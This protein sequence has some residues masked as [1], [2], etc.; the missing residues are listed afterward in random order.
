VAEAYG[1]LPL[2]FEPNRGQSDPLIRFLARGPGYAVF[3]TPEQALLKLLGPKP[4]SVRMQLAGASADA[5]VEGL[6]ALPGKSH[7]FLGDD[8]ARWRRDIPNYAQ[9][10]VAGVYPG[11]DL[12][13]YGNPQRLEYDFVLAPGSDPGRIRLQFHSLDRTGDIAPRIQDGDLL[14]ETAAG[15]LRFKQPLAYQEIAGVRREIAAHYE[16]HRADDG[17]AQVGFA[18]AAYD[19][20]RPLVID[21]TLVYST[22][23]G[24]SLADIGYGIAVDGSGRAY[25]TGTTSSNPFPTSGGAYDGSFGGGQDVFVARL[26]AAGSAL[27][28]STYLG[29]AGTDIAYGIDIDAGGNAYVTGETSGGF[30]TTDGSGGTIAAY[31]A[32]YGGGASDG[33][34]AKLNNTGSALLYS[35][36]LGGSGAD[37]ARAIAVD[38]AGIAYLTG[39]TTSPSTGGSA[40]PTTAGAFDATCGTEGT[41]NGGA[42]DAFVTRINTATGGA[43][44]LL[45]STYLGGNGADVG[46]AIDVDA[47]A[48]AY[49]TGETLSTN[50]T[51]TTGALDP[52]CGTDGGCNGGK[53]DAFVTKI[54]TAAA[55]GASIAFSTYLGGEDADIGYGIAVD[56]SGNVYITG[57]TGSAGFPVSSPFQG[58]LA[59]APD[60][61]VTKLGSAGTPILYSTFLGG[62]GADSGRAIKVDGGGSAYVTGVT[63]SSNFPVANAFQLDQTADDAFVV[64]LTSGG[65]GLA[66][67]TYFGGAGADRGL[68]VAV[69]ANCNAYITGDTTSSGPPF[70]LLPTGA[71]YDD[72]YNGAG[73][74]FVA[75]I[76]PNANE[77]GCTGGPP[78]ANPTLT[79]AGSGSGSGTVT[80]TGINCTIAAGVTSGDCTESYSTGATA[81]LT[82]SAASGS[83]FGGWSGGSGNCT[84]T[85]TPCTTA[86]LTADATVTATFTS[87]DTA[88]DSFS[89]ISYNAVG[90]GTSYVS[91]PATITGINAAANVSVSGG[92]YCLSSQLGCRCDV[93]DWTTAAGTVT[94]NQSACVRHTSS[95][96]GGVSVTTTLT[97]GGVSSDFT[98]STVTVAPADTPSVQLLINGVAA[99]SVPHAQPLAVGW[100]VSNVVNKELFLLYRTPGAGGAWYFVNAAGQVLAAVDLNLVTPLVASGPSA[101]TYTLFSNVALPAGIYEAYVIVENTA[102]GRLT[103][104]GNRIVG[105]ARYSLVTVQ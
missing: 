81:T 38:G 101:G 60:V 40:F 105:F 69:D 45:Y 71:V 67:S 48:N 49:V 11:I 30:P 31:S 28:Y 74:V 94:N 55:G 46:R 36:Y 20:G 66:Y 91:T 98:T 13:Y 16:I 83:S 6:E 63:A 82:A 10:R 3:I 2:V 18:L 23:V 59:T 50:F 93:R 43:A 88:P 57:E 1:R 72:G 96:N 61:F 35:T 32:S 102:D 25:V 95:A 39:S 76:Q 53:K 9:V 70:P 7:Y 34:L 77:G 14:I 79:I 62:N 68:A 104:T 97:V 100:T 84:G 19:A 5:P 15:T 99:G 103:V 52:T 17:P 64:R 78:G 65:S 56:G 80:A 58:A 73:D 22:Y 75:R 86:G 85:T 8:P 37:V 89:F 44:G 12:V 51:L 26:T 41:C 47:S 90:V 21:P 92:E 4:A 27:E 54:N 29:G 33:F 24:G 42:S 87:A